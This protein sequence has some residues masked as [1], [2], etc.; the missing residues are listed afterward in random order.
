MDVFISDTSTRHSCTPAI[1]TLHLHCPHTA[2]KLLAM[3]EYRWK[4]GVREV[5]AHIRA[6]AAA[7]SHP[8]PYK[9]WGYVDYII[10]L[11]NQY[12]SSFFLLHLSRF[13]QTP[14][15]LHAFV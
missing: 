10:E 14:H 13:T 7:A 9:G 4:M 2:R 6:A 1:A 8:L 15:R 5:G 12:N 11:D 3:F